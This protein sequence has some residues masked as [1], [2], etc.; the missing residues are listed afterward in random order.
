VLRIRLWLA[1]RF[2]ERVF[3]VSTYALASAAAASL[4]CS[5]PGYRNEAARTS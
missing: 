3:G 5:V 2:A 4:I 1:D